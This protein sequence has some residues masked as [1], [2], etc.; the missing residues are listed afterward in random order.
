MI[1]QNC[2]LLMLNW[3]DSQEPFALD[4]LIYINILV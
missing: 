3:A 4:K 1:D 2:I